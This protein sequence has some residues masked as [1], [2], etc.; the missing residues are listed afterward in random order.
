M[1]PDARLLQ[2]SVGKTY[3]AAIALQLVQEGRLSLDDPISKHLGREPW[4][5]RLPNASRIT[6]RHLMRHTSGLVRW[7]FDSAATAVMRAQPFKT[8]TPEERLAYLLDKRPLRPGAVLLRHQLHRARN[9]IERITGRPYCDALRTASSGPS[10]I[11][12]HPQRQP[13]PS[14][15][16]ATPG[17]RTT[18]EAS[19]RRSPTACSP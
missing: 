17:R 19:T 11:Q 5:H 10:R 1:R 2:G 18:S 8:W 12:H 16:N 15:V 3:V 4:F 14:V 7:E 9:I 13:A 6:I